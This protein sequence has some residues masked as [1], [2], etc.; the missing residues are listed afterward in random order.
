MTK[1]NTPL[2][3]FSANRA[4]PTYSFF[5]YEENN[6]QISDTSPQSAGY[7]LLLTGCDFNVWF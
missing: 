1:N 4:S 2:H 3:S 7:L 6:P 5:I